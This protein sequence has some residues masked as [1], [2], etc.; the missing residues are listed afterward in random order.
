MPWNVIVMVCGVTVL[1]ALLE[2]AQGIDLL[3]SLVA[4][5]V[6]AGLRSPPSSRS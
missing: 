5:F 3:V 1:I 6:D 2:K 4:R